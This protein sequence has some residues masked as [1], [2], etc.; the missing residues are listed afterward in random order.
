[1]FSGSLLEAVLVYM[2]FHTPMGQGTDPPMS[3]VDPLT[4]C[5][6]KVAV[7]PWGLQRHV[8]RDL[9]RAV[10]MRCSGSEDALVQ[11]QVDKASKLSHGQ[12]G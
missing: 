2:G 3:L 1:M 8:T 12:R 11:R 10:A 4:R 5:V 6:G 9:C 7:L